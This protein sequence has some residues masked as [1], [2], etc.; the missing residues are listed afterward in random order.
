MNLDNIPQE[1]TALPRW[2]CAWRNSKIPMQARQRKG[3]SSVNPE[4]WSSFEDARKAV[5]W[6]DY[7]NL[8][9]V[10]NGDGI[11]G[12]DI[13]RGY[14]DD[15]FLSDISIDCM[16]A[17]RSY[18]EQSR[19]GRGI[20]IYVRGDLPFKGKN[21]R[22]GVEIYRESRFFIVTGERI[23]YSELVE[24]Q[25][26]IDY[27]V[28]KYFPEEVKQSGEKHGRIYSPEYYA[29]SPNKI[30]VRPAYPAIQPG[31]R[32]LSL[33]SLAGQL[34]TQGYSAGQIY[35]ELLKANEQACKPPLPRGEVE[36]IVRSI[37]KYDEKH[38]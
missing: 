4:T 31:M 33:T 7:D 22:A 20:H 13:D 38:N 2:V 3:A 19:S 25:L 24:N 34:H 35:N 15:G 27:I 30:A 8:G 1:M 6:G 11:V 23:I 36:S 18:T 16:R 12:I 14:D 10:F 17:C 26:A 37:T 32:N 29:P 5:E 9:F 21:N 28:S